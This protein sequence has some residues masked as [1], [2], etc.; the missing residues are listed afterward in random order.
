MSLEHGAPP[1]SPP[2]DLGTWSWLWGLSKAGQRSRPFPHPR[3]SP[4]QCLWMERKGLWCG[5][6]AAA[7]KPHP[8]LYPALPTGP[9]IPTITSGGEGAASQRR[10]SVCARP[11][12]RARG[13]Q[14]KRAS[15][16]PPTPSLPTSSIQE[17]ELARTVKTSSSSKIYF[18]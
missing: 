6:R 11:V 8:C 3:P 10:A 14:T 12:T 17:T 1:D 4:Q 13:L 15:S 9:H 5:P 16:I 18:Y 2:M 7:E